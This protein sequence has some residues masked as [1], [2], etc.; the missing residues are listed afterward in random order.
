[1]QSI[2]MKIQYDKIQYCLQLYYKVTQ[3]ITHTTI[4]TLVLKKSF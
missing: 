2:M 1:M 3:N 4:D